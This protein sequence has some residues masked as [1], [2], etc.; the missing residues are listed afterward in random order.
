VSVVVSARIGFVL[1][2]LLIAAATGC[3]SGGQSKPGA[4]HMTLTFDGQEV[5]LA[6][7]AQCLG[8]DKYLMVSTAV[9]TTGGDVIASLTTSPELGVQSVSI[10]GVDGDQKYFWEPTS[11]AGEAMTASKDGNTITVRGRIHQIKDANV[12]KSIEITANCPT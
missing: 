4:P 11:T 8:G 7:P 10:N 2:A 12:K 5:E 1:A 9:A 3:S 6:S